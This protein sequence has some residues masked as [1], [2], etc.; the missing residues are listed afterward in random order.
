VIQQRLVY[1]LSNL[2]LNISDDLLNTYKSGTK[3]VVPVTQEEVDTLKSLIISLIDK[4]KSD[5]FEGKFQ[6]YSEI[7]TSTGFNVASIYDA[8]TFNNFHEGIHLGY[9][10]SIRKFI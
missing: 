6:N 7:T 5:F 1:A 9:I 3:P 8:I 10:M 4:T 2:P